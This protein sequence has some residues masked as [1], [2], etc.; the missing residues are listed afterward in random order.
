MEKI[1]ENEK[2]VQ[3]LSFA[4][5]KHHHQ[6]RKVNGADY[7]EHPI[8]VANILLEFGAKK[9]Q[10]IA[11]LLHDVIEDTPCTRKEIIDAFGEKVLKLV[12]ACT[13]EEYE[14]PTTRE[15]WEDRKAKALE[16]VKKM[17]IDAV[18]I[19]VADKIANNLSL[20]EDLKI[21]GRETWSHFNASK[22]QKGR[23]QGLMQEVF[24]ERL[25]KEHPLVKR[26]KAIYEGIF[27][28]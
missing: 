26:A 17:N 8:L 4:K 6:K 18:P 9:E 14:D 23:H 28:D 20:Q 1:E 21:Y 24:V 10:I 15:N 11:A 19:K 22:E 13:D 7:I 2:Y 12:E 5:E 3:A 16:K 27:L 25:G